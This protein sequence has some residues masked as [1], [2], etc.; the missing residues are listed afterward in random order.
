[1]N[2]SCAGG[3]GAFIDQMA[4]LLSI[5]P[6]EMNYLAQSSRA[7]LH[8]RLALRRVCQERHPAAHQS[9]RAKRRHLPRASF[10]AVVNQT[11]AGL[12]QGRPI[13]GKV[14]VSR[15]A[16][17]LL[18]A[19]SRQRFRRNARPARGRLPGKLA[20]LRGAGRGAVRRARRGST[21]ASWTRGAARLRRQP[22]SYRAAAR[23]CFTARR[24]VRRVC[25]APR[26]AP[27]SAPTNPAP[28][29]A[30]RGVP[31]ASTPA[32]TTV[33]A[34][35]H[36]P[37]TAASSTRATSSNTGDPVAIV[38][39]SAAGVLR[40]ASRAAKLVASC[41]PPATARTSSAARSTL[42]A[43]VVETIAHFTA[44]KHFDPQVDFIIDIGGQ[45][46]KCFK[47]RNGAIDNIFL[48]EACSSGCG[49]FLQTFAG[50]ARATAWRNSPRWGLFAERPVDLG[51]RC[52]VFMNSSVKQAQ[53]DGAPVEDISA[54]LSISVV[55]N[56]LYKV[57][58]AA[59]AARSG[60]ADRRAGRHLPQRRGAARLRAGDWTR[61]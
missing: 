34:G 61:R 2:G 10:S 48:N 18:R 16:A 23:R 20:V 59:S 33:K 22:A 53:K 44:A 54:G 9:G 21:L 25:R 19:A 41:A 42:D 13:E 40:R 50:R 52:T 26:A 56:A 14:A 8:H 1:M 47:I 46:I 5:T 57:I 36:G 27:P 39:G 60:R 15:R 51:S 37:R 31:S 29:C 12:A 32:R 55:K 11:I 17:D 7:D 6:D 58:R 35:G 3:T 43:G 4:T 38:R 49:S 24:G 45:D 28:D 30:G